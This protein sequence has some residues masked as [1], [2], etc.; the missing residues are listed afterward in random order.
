MGQVTARFYV[1][2][3][4][5]NVTKTINFFPCTFPF[6]ENTTNGFSATGHHAC[7]PTPTEISTDILLPA[8]KTFGLIC[9][10]SIYFYCWLVEDVS[11]QTP[12]LPPAYIPTQSCKRTSFVSLNPARARNHKP[13]PGSSPTF[14]F[15]ARFRPESQFIG[16]VK[17]CATAK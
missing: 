16:E 1:L 15:E 11:F 4:S 7:R 8:G 3:K 6:F 2:F 17:I 13:E 5:L 9:V 10:I 14:I 12:L